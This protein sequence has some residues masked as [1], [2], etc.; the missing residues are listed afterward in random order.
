MNPTLIV[1]PFG[2]YNRAG[3]FAQVTA[4]GVKS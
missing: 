2:E 4:F 3:H 1:I